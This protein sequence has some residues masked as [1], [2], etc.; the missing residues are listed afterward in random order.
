[1]WWKTPSLT[2]EELLERLDPL[3]V[4][5]QHV[6]EMVEKINRG[7]GCVGDLVT[8]EKVL[9]QP[10]QIPGSDH[11]PTMLTQPEEIKYALKSL[12]SELHLEVHVMNNQYPCYLLCRIST[13]WN[14]PPTVLEEL[15]VSS[16]NNFF[17]DD[18][19]TIL[20]KSGYSKTFLR[21][22]SFRKKL[23]E[24]LVETYGEPPDESMCDEILEAVAKLILAAAWYE[25]QQLPFF[26]ADVFKLKNFC[27]ALELVAFILG[28]DLY[29]IASAI[30]DGNECV[31]DFFENVYENLPLAGLLDRLTRCSVENFAD[32]EA[33]A[34]KEFEELNRAF[35]V[36]L[37]KTDMLH[38]LKNLEFYK[39]ILGCF[40]NLRDVAG[41]D[42]WTQV[43]HQAVEEIEEISAA[44]TRHLVSFQN[45]RRA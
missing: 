23:Q 24:H 1:M 15:Y 45:S 18:R 8:L 4:Q 19:F 17:P 22:S 13:D 29:H 16:R 34:R 43:L 5:I 42:Y 25:D 26:V 41:E 7:K 36:F 14:T 28:S 2:H 21:L 11:A 30:Q 35:S 33:A 39:I 44:C 38:N 32:L 31:I 37:S 9:K 6:D 12:S 20:L 40:G 3:L 10:F 27:S